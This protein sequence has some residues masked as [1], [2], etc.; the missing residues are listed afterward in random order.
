[1]LISSQIASGSQLAVCVWLLTAFLPPLAQAAEAPVG[2]WFSRLDQLVLQLRSDGSF[3]ITTP[4]GKRPPVE[5]R[6]EEQG[7]IITFRNAPTAPV[8]GGEPGQY[9]WKRDA[10]GV[11]RFELLH[12]ACQPRVTHMKHPFDPAPAI[13]RPE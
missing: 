11:L 7:G 13:E 6:W 1:M 3:A 10:S 8:C 9:R 4:E 2:R 12:D 5:G